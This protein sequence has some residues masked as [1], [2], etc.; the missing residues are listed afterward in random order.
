MYLLPLRRSPA[1][2]SVYGLHCTL[3]NSESRDLFPEQLASIWHGL[4]GRARL[5]FHVGRRHNDLHGTSWVGDDRSLVIQMCRRV[6]E[7]DP[8]NL[9]K[10]FDSLA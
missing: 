9:K 3:R 7:Q 5:V 4:E 10:G 8:A 2:D 1:L 6:E